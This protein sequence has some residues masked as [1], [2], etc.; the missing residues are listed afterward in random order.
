VSAPAEAEVSS[1]DYAPM[2]DS[3]HVAQGISTTAH[4][5]KPAAVIDNSEKVNPITGAPMDKKATAAKTSIKNQRLVKGH[6][7]DAEDGTGMPGVNIRVKG[8]NIATTTDINGDYEISVDSAFA[9]L[10]FSF[11][12][13]NNQEVSA[14]NK[15]NIEVGMTTDY[16]ALSEVV[17][18]GYASPRAELEDPNNVYTYAE[19]K[20]GRKAY[21]N[22]LVQNMHYPQQAIDNKVEGRV[23]VQFAVETNGM[24]DEFKVLKTPGYGCDE[25][26]LRLIKEGPPWY[27]TTR[28]NVPIKGKVKV[29][30]KFTL[31]K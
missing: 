6:V 10:V 2:V 4:S 9:D 22:Y 27:P 31:K 11:V 8:T 28:N 12:G 19:P 3:V 29:R 1:T 21:R 7:T 15:D 26:V 5:S 14:E 16:A 18:V 25:E 17:V 24:I 20:G 13:Y 23:T 30:L